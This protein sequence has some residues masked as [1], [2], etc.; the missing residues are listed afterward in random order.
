M[1]ND[2]GKKECVRYVEAGKA[3]M[4]TWSVLLKKIIVI[5][6]NSQASFSI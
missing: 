6:L 4:K 3:G 2:Q 5:L 1:S